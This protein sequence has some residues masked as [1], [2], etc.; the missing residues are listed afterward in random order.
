MWLSWAPNKSG[1]I[2]DHGT[3]LADS[4]E[5][6]LKEGPDSSKLKNWLEKQAECYLK[7]NLCLNC[8]RCIL[9]G[10]TSTES[11]R[12]RVLNIKHRIEYST[13][14]SLLPYEEIETSI[15]FNAIN[16]ASQSTRQALG[17]RY[18]VQAGYSFPIDYHLKISDD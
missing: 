5:Q 18:A 11:G 10:A 6:V 17:T 4:R 14:Y 9:F 7:D 12:G 1:G 3:D 13:A 16:D 8:P 2:T 15:T